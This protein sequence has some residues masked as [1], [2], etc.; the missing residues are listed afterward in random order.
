MTELK[1]EGAYGK[2]TG[3][4]FKIDN[5]KED[6][7]PKVEIYTYELGDTSS[8]FATKPREERIYSILDLGKTNSYEIS[9]YSL[10]R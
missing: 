5:Q 6:F 7:M 3:V 8:I 4:R 2:I 9:T 1:A 10:L